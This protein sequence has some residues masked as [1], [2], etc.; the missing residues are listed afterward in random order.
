MLCVFLRWKAMFNKIFNNL[1]LAK[2]LIWRGF[3]RFYYLTTEI[4][5]QNFRKPINFKPNNI[6]GQGKKVCYNAAFVMRGT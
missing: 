6:H 4:V 2:T 5:G 1:Y 3:I